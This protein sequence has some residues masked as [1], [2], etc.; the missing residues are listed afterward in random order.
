M[1]SNTEGKHRAEFVQSL[2]QGNRSIENVTIKSGQNIQAGEVLGRELTGSAT[3][4]ADAQNTGDGVMGTVTVTD[5]AKVGTY[6]LT[7]LE[8]ATD[9]GAFMVEDPGGIN[10]GEGNVA[11]AFSAG[12]LSFTLADGATDYV[13]GDQ[14]SIVVTET[15]VVYT[16]LPNDGSEAARCI[17]LEDYNASS[18]ALL[19]AVVMRDSEVNGNELVWPASQSAANKTLA[20]DQLAALGIIVR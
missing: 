18:A 13:P 15:S 5:Q 16:A 6:M 17:A 14:F 19:G 1:A 9:A 12:G 11:A 20:I 7:F 10:M 8:A 2:A 3:A 4:T